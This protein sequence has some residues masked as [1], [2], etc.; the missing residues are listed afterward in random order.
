MTRL[1]GALGIILVSTALC[2]SGSCLENPYISINPVGDHEAGETF[3][4]NG[5]TS[6][7]GGKTLV[8]EIEPVRLHP[9]P[10][11]EPP[12]NT[13]SLTGRTMTED[14]PGGKTTWSFIVN[15]T[16][17]MPDYYTLRVTSFDPPIIDGSDD[18]TLTPPGKDRPGISTVPTRAYPDPTGAPFIY[19]ALILLVISGVCIVYILRK[20]R[21][22][23]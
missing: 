19:G 22:N 21:N 2:V 9:A 7:V 11:H 16:S 4:I 3:T 8:I 17:L 13:T 18:F 20:K 5:T 23:S 1:T 6:L 10:S 15:S 14:A 12:Q